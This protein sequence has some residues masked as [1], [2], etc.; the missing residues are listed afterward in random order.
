MVVDNRE[1]KRLAQLP[2][3][4]DLGSVQTVGL[5][6]VVGQLGLESSA[7]CGLAPAAAPARGA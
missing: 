2:V 6:Q 4:Q 1:E 3:L 7:I 5:P